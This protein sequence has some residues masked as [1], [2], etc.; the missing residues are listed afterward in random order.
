[1]DWSETKQRARKRLEGICRLCKHCDG[2]ACAGE[3]PGIGG[4][5]TGTSFTNNFEALRQVQLNLRTLH[6]ISDP[7]LR[8]EIFGRPLAL[9]VLG[10]AVAGAGVNFRGRIG[11]EE[12]CLAQVEGAK[13]AGTLA[14]TG[15]G[16]AVEIFA[17]GI[18][19]LTVTGGASIPVIKPRP[20]ADIINRLRRAEEAGAVAAG[21]DVDAAGLV[22]MRLLGQPVGPLSPVN[23]EMICQSTRLPIIVKG[24]MTA[25]EAVLAGEAGA[26]AIVVSNHGGRALDHTPGTATVLPAIARAVKGRLKIIADGGI[27]T[28]TDILKFLALGADAVLVGRPIVWATFG[29]GAEGVQLL[30]ERLATELKIAMILTGCASPDRAGKYLLTKQPAG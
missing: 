7:E 1:M 30:Y 11:E 23:L 24:I 29:G 26:K 3:I 12:F 19:A 28:G 6:E 13:S 18:K 17:A 10:A 2:R 16:P 8:T 22:N 21:I 20:L 4:V 15:D 25:D 27:R 14:L 9:P 5:G